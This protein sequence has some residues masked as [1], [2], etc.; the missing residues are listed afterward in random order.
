MAA[1]LW[2][3]L[4]LLASHSSDLDGDH[5]AAAQDLRCWVHEGQLSCQWERGP[6][7]TG[8]VHYRMFWRDVRL[9]PAHN[10]ECPHYHSLDVNTAGPAPH[11][12]HEGCTLDLD[13]VLGS[14]PNSPDLVPQVTITVNGSGRAGPVP[15][16]DNTVDLQRAEVLAPPT[17]TVECNGSEAHAR[18]VARNRFHHGLLGYTLQVNQSSRSEP[19][20][21]NVS[22][23][24][25]WVPNAGAISF[26][27]KSRSEVYPRKLSSWSEAWGLVCP[28]EVMPVKTA[29]VT[30]VATVLGAG[31]VAA[32][33]LLWWRKS[34]LYR[35]CPPIP[36]LRLPLAGEMVVWEPALEDCEVTPVTDA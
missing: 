14:T 29:L 22:I 17:L 31:L 12:G 24:H 16:M 28:P 35:L 26:R 25:F 19:Q 20:E 33:L 8:D 6:K 11:G 15:C 18:W 36:R 30:S 4:G 5:E 13:T 10:R 32:G 1:N 3:I 34:L 7:A 27:V 21:Y 23:P 2:L 9:G